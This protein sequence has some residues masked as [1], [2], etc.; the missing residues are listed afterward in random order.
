MSATRDILFA[1]SSYSGGYRMMRARMC[2]STWEPK[3]MRA[4]P[5][6]V[7]S[8]YSDAVMRVALSRLKKNGF[9]QNRRGIWSITERG[10][11]Y[12][13][14]KIFLG[15][16]RKILEKKSKSIIIAFDIPETQ[17]KR[18]EWLRVE[19]RNLGFEMLQRSVWFG[20][21]PL[22]ADFIDSL[23]FLKILSHIKFFEAKEADIA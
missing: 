16:H 10:K 3:E 4:R 13:L 5:T 18:R 6:A 14:K 8:A 20:P 11:L 12:A 19:L 9:V 7:Q 2:G 15:H 21:A 22:P 1:L 23:K 17:K